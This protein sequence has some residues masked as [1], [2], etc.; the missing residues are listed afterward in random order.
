MQITNT[1]L[2]C[3]LNAKH[4]LPPRNLTTSSPPPRSF[5]LL[6]LRRRLLR[7]RLVL[8]RLLRLHQM[9]PAQVS[10]LRPV[11]FATLPVRPSRSAAFLASL[12]PLR[13][14]SGAIEHVGRQLR[15]VSC[16]PVTAVRTFAEMYKAAGSELAVEVGTTLGG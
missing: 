3:G 10:A 14:E 12:V 5:I 16:V 13:T 11:A 7:R 15:P 8:R 6:L 1:K 9:R 4:P 2:L